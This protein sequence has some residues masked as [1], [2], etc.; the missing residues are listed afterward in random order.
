MT[1]DADRYDEDFDSYEAMYPH[2]LSD[3]RV[4]VGA[5]IVDFGESWTARELEKWVRAARREA[6]AA[7]LADELELVEEPTQ[8]LSFGGRLLPTPKGMVMGGVFQKWLA[9]PAEKRPGALRASSRDTELGTQIVATRK[10]AKEVSIST[11]GKR[12]ADGDRDAGDDYAWVSLEAERNDRYQLGS[13]QSLSDAAVVRGDSAMDQDKD[14]VYVVLRRML[15]TDVPGV[16]D[17]VVAG[18]RPAPTGG[19]ADS[20]AAAGKGKV[21]SGDLRELRDGSRSGDTER[22]GEEGDL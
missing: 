1:A 7:R 6:R 19:K 13:T 5:G 21:D 14:G 18:L 11:P 12:D 2:P 9:T 16:I 22:R 20:G 17:R 3:E 15:L 4:Q 8:M 10:A